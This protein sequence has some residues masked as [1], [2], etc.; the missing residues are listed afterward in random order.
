MSCWSNGEM[1]R[2][3]ELMYS[4]LVL[5]SSVLLEKTAAPAMRSL[6]VLAVI[7]L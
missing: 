5:A 1:S 4:K 7:A 6:K 3:F 2:S